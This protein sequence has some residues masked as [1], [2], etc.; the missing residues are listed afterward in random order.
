[1]RI[2]QVITDTDRRG[3]QT[4]AVELGPRLVAYGHEVRTVALVSGASGGLGTPALGAK[5]FGPSTLR[6]LRDEMG[7]VE[8]TIAHGSSTLLACA[9]AGLGRGRP[10]VYRQIS[11]PLYWAP[12]TARR[13]RVRLSYRRAR[14]VVALTSEAA[15]VLDRSFGV[16]RQ[17]ITVI[18]NGVDE[19][20]YRPTSATA[21]EAARRTLNLKPADFVIAFVGAVAAEKGI[22]DLVASL[23]DGARLI[24]VGDGPL[25]ISVSQD[26]RVHAIGVIND[27][28]SIYAAADVVALPSWTE[29]QPAV[30]LEAGLC[31]R[32]IVATAVGD[33]PA[34]VIEGKTG[35]LVPPHDRAA[36]HAAL[37]DIQAD[38]V[39]RARLGAAAAE[40]VREHYSL[41]AV[42][43]H[44]SQM[45]ETIFE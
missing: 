38:A 26:P 45:L 33:L 43:E 3:A 4:F 15:D 12:T 16:R 32:P 39:L 9:L 28:A 20:R 23:P 35:R 14:H 7:Q 18:P 11:D 19:R 17:R 22:D 42:A 31:G 1:V 24:V 8:A 34:M 13:L 21:A 6:R 2:L 41:T 27:L 37:C 5:E 36:L 44:W 40:H 29:Q 10:F 25:R 30:V